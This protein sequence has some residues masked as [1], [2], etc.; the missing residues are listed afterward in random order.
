MQKA[1]ASN[2]GDPSQA[3]DLRAIRRDQS[4]P[5]DSECFTSKPG[6]PHSREC[7]MFEAF[8]I[9]VGH[10]ADGEAECCFVSLGVS[11]S[12]GRNE[13]VVAVVVMVVVG[14]VLWSTAH[15]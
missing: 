11:K 4:W 3:Q 8:R 7:R 6:E 10:A 12:L 15:V 13:D 5:A 14:C 1:A 2:R 9:N